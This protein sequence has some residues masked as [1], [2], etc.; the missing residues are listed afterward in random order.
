[1]T[2][3]IDFSSK[4]V[5]IFFAILICLSGFA[6][7]GESVISDSHTVEKKI[8][9]AV[10]P[11]ENLSGT[12]A[13]IKNI[14]QSLINKLKKQGLNVLDE[15]VL[16][17]FMARHRIRYTG[18]IDSV[19][20][21]AFRKETG[22]EAVLITSLELYTD[23][24]PPKIALTCRLVS[25]GD[26]P[27]ILWMDGIG[28]AGDDSPGILGLGLIKNPQ[29]LLKKALR[30]L[31]GSLTGYLSD[32]RE[33]IAAQGK[34]RKKFRPKVSYRSPVIAQDI[35]YTVAVIP[36]FNLSERKYAGEIMVL[37]FVRQLRELENFDVIEL[38]V[39]RHALLRLRIIMNTGVS[40]AD[41]D[42]IFSRL[43]TDLILTGKVLDY[44]DYQGSAGKSKVDFSVLV[45]ERK[46]REVVWSSKSNNEGDDGVFFFD[47]G[48]VNTAHSMAS[49]MTRAV[50]GMIVK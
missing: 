42:V 7:I 23:M 3:S 22:A 32:K 34:R 45:I 4:L 18:G 19:I 8:H 38:G 40:F 21:Q 49:E 28:L 39:V 43:G 47:W 14:R 33:R 6:T 50:V 9:I 29:T 1:M 17:R 36:F 31:S 20:A 30:L 46:S 11:V 48:R 27:V 37:H 44:Q 16:E 12:A 10:L 25:T 41:T 13:P 5:I 24:Y 35:K 15:E 2:L 26:N